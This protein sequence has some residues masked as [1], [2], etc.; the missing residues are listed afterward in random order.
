MYKWKRFHGCAVVDVQVEHDL[1]KQR[2]STN[3]IIWSYIALLYPN[4]ACHHY[5]L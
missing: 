3:I 2:K 4:N 5:C 1:Y